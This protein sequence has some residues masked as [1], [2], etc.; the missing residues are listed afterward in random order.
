MTL[1]Q[2]ANVECGVHDH[3]RTMAVWRIEG[4]AAASDLLILIDL[5]SSA[6]RERARSREPT[7]V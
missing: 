2:G 5:I 7:A 6:S 1:G 4:A 3:Q